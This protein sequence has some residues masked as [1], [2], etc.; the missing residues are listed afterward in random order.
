MLWLTTSSKTEMVRLAAVSLMEARKEIRILG[1][2]VLGFRVWGLA[3]VH[4]LELGK[5]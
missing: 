3:G 4:S 1:A 2:G 5:V